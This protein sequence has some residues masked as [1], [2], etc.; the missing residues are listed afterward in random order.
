LLWRRR[1]APVS[2]FLSSDECIVEG[3]TASWTADNTGWVSPVM[4]S[5]GAYRWASPG[6]VASDY[7][8]LAGLFAGT[9]SPGSDATGSW[10][11]LGTT[12]SWLRTTDGQFSIQVSIRRASDNVVVAG[13]V[14]IL[15]WRVHAPVP[16]P[17]DEGGPVGGGPGH[18]GGGIETP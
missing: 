16:P 11:S 9:P 2:L 3:S 4:G 10:L 7:Q 12:R 17:G 5:Y 6:F 15:I 8:I 14:T 18:G 1:V 13:P